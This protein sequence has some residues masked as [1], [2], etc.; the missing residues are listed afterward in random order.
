MEY[1]KIGAA[2]LTSGYFT[3]GY[4]IRG[5]FTTRIFHQRKFHHRQIS[6]PCLFRHPVYFT[7]LSILSPF[8]FHYSVH[9]PVKLNQPVIS[10]QTI[11]ATLGAI[12]L[13]NTKYAMNGKLLMAIYGIN[14]KT[15]IRDHVFFFLLLKTKQ[16][17]QQ[18]KIL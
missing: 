2:Q 1:T 9:Q 8:L 10:T 3:R 16:I 17:M 7:T 4:F 5:N 14:I 13:L 11:S 15:I 12:V 6:S 18:R